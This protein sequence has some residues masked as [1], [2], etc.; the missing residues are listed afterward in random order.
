MDYGRYQFSV[1]FWLFSCPF[2]FEF[3][4]CLSLVILTKQVSRIYNSQAFDVPQTDHGVPLISDLYLC[5]IYFKQLSKGFLLV[6]NHQRS[7]III[8]FS[9]FILEQ[10]CWYIYICILNYFCQGS[11]VHIMVLIICSDM[12]S[13]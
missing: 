12:H 2:F 10:A 11:M 5:N 8:V 3:K 4:K 1:C 9:N 7:H 13:I 6:G